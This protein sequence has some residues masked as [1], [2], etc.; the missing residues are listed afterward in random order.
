[1]RIALVTCATLPDLASDDSVLLGSLESRGVDVEAVVWDDPDAD[2]QAYDLVVVRSAWDYSQRL[3]EFLDWASG[4][5]EVTRLA[6]AL[7][8]VRWNIDKHY[9]CELEAEGVPVVP[10]AWL[11]PDRHLSSRAL[12]TRYPANGDFVI[13]PAVSAGSMDTGRYTAMDATS[14]G[15]AVVHA[16]RLLTAGRT[17]M[18]QRYLTSVDTYGEHAHV[19]VAGEYSHS[20]LKAAMLDGPDVAVGGVYRPE[21]TGPLVASIEEVTLARRVVATARQLLLRAGGGQE[22]FLYARVD[23]VN[24]DSGHPV[25]RELELVEPTLFLTHDSSAVD[26]FSDAMV[27]LAGR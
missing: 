3:D 1:M 10:T 19:F 15:L 12:H 25:L 9:L 5:S 17:V 16:K 8:V 26:R 18:V 21:E 22:P 24:D 6:N 14:R 20:V 2:W 11:E 13:K 7:P 23:L 4:V 27:A